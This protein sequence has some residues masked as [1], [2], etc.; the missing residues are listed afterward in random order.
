MQTGSP[1]MLDE[2]E[3]WLAQAAAKGSAEAVSS[4]AQLLSASEEPSKRIRARELAEWA[5]ELGDRSAPALIAAMDAQ[6][7]NGEVR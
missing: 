6:S 3:R 7:F 1:E 4:L 2:A 5:V